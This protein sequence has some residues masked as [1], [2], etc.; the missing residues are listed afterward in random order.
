MQTS[1]PV[2]VWMLTPQKMP[3]GAQEFKKSFDEA[4]AKNAFLL[5][6][7]EGEANGSEASE[8]DSAVE[9][10][11][12]PSPADELAAKTEKLAVSEAASNHKP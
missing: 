1:I 3:A 8:A 4:V 5:D 2:P 10:P 11:A 6:D 9:A 7:T 12:A